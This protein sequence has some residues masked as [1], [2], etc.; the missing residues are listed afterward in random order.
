MKAVV[1]HEY[2]GPEVLKFEEY[3][4]PVSGPGEVLVRVADGNL[5]VCCS[6]PTSDVV[7]DL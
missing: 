5:L 3:P 1:V 4:D 7:I 6:Q 2:G